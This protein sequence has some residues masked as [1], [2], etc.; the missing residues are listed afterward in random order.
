MQNAEERRNEVLNDL[1]RRIFE[2]FSSHYTEWKTCVDLVAIIDVLCSLA[3]FSRNL[4]HMCIPELVD[5]D[6]VQLLNLI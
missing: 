4:N 6:K 5:S 2:K 1:S 3:E